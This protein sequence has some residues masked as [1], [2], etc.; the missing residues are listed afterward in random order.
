MPDLFLLKSKP[1]YGYVSIIKNY[2]KAAGGSLA[3]GHQQIVS[4]NIMPKQF[5]NNWSFQERH[6]FHKFLLQ[7][8]SRRTCS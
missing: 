7:E 5:F 4:S 2:G 3:H 1:T 8:K 6:S